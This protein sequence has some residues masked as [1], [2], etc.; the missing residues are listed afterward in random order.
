MSWQRHFLALRPDQAARARLAALSLPVQARRTHPADLHVTLAFLGTLDVSAFGVVTEVADGFAHTR[1]PPLV[2]LDR[3]EYWPRS[4]VLCAVG[5]AEQDSLV[6]DV[7]TLTAALLARGLSVETRPFRPHVTLAR[8]KA[9]EPVEPV[10]WSPAVTWSA[11]ELVL[12]ASRESDREGPRYE[13][14]HRTRFGLRIGG[15]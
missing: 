2:R 12:M 14:L 10:P 5:S 6:E 13:A 15:D 11:P 3:L 7:A 4:R 1:A 9:G 8:L